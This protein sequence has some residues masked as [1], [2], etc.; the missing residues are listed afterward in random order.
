MV[1]TTVL[2]FTSREIKRAGWK[3]SGTLE[4][5]AQLQWCNLINSLGGDAKIVSG[6]G[7]FG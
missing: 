5:C 3:F 1:G 7:S 2:R 4:E 6:P